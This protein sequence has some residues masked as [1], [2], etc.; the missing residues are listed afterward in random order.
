MCREGP[1]GRTE[2]ACDLIKML[3]EA[4]SIDPA[5]KDVNGK[6]PRDYAVENNANE[7]AALL[8]IGASAAVQRIGITLQ[9]AIQACDIKAI[10]AL[11][12][13]GEDIN[14]ISEET[15]RSAIFYFFADKMDKDRLAIFDF[16]LAHGLEPNGIIDEKE[17]TCL[18]F[19]CGKNY[20]GRWNYQIVERLVRSGWD[21]NQSN[22]VGMTPLM[23]FTEHGN[24]DTQGIAA[25]LIKNGADVNKTDMMGYD[26]LMIAGFNPL[27]AS[28]KRIAELL[29]DAGAD[30][31]RRNKRNESALDIAV[32]KKQE[33]IIKLLKERNP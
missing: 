23:Y 3:L 26:A 12:E 1:K 15:G 24:E 4:K 22:K 8:S 9:E 30:P 5:A 11:L 27:E 6:T 25:F 16:L 17:D 33:T 29:L 20:G 21:L 7:L 28:G 14:V 31:S 19:A 10:A 18:H 13:A 2:S 32:Q